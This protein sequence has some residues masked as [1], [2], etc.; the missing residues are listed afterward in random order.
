MAGKPQA[1]AGC[2]EVS[3]DKEGRESL[4]LRSSRTQRSGSSLFP[5]PQLLDVRDHIQEQLESLSP[6]FDPD[7][8]GLEG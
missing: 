1:S 8:T 3:G 4:V 7:V 6:M 2:S 5:D